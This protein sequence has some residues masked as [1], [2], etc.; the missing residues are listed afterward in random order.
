MCV[1]HAR[2]M[3][4]V[5]SMNPASRSSLVFAQHSPTRDII[6][7]NPSYP[8]TIDIIATGR[9]PP[10]SALN[11]GAAAGRKKYLVNLIGHV[12][13]SC[14]HPR[15]MSC[16]FPSAC[17]V[18]RRPQGGAYDGANEK[19]KKI[20]GGDPNALPFTRPPS[21]RRDASSAAAGPQPG[22]PGARRRRPG[23]RRPGAGAG[24]A[25]S[26]RP[27]AAAGPRPAAPG[28]PRRRA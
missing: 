3:F 15:P 5:M 27:G 19:G 6:A 7:M 28:A 1:F 21:A 26:R 9:K 13:C 20:K 17:F 12:A 23:R 2:G 4:V 22:A 18:S 25:H 11:A 10:K 16:A 8:T 24:A 14:T